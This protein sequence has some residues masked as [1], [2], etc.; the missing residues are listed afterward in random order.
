MKKL[1]TVLAS[2]LAIALSASA[3]S[4]LRGL[5]KVDHKLSTTP[6]ASFS[7][8]LKADDNKS[9]VRRAAAKAEDPSAAANLSINDLE[10]DYICSAYS[11]ASDENDK[12]YGWDVWGMTSIYQT[13][14]ASDT[15]L[16]IVGFMGT[17]DSQCNATFNPADGSMLIPGG[18]VLTVVAETGNTLPDGS[19]ETM[20]A[21]FKFYI[22]HLNIKGNTL[23]DQLPESN[24]PLIFTYDAAEH[25]YTWECEVNGE[26][27]S[28]LIVLERVNE[29]GSSIINPTTGSKAF[30]D[31]LAMVDLDA[32]NGI[33]QFEALDAEKSTK[34]QLAFAQQANYMYGEVTADNKLIVK[35]IYDYGFDIK[36]EFDINED[37]SISALDAHLA[38]IPLQ[39]SQ[40]S[41]YLTAINPETSELDEN[42][43]ITYQG[44]IQ[45]IPTEVG[46]VPVSVFT[47]DQML[48]DYDITNNYR[49]MWE[50]IKN[51][52][53]TFFF[54]AFG[55][56]GVEDVTVADNE[57]A[58]V[59]YFNLQGVRVA[60][61]GSGLY[62]VRQGAKTYKTF[63]K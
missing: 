43:P 38:D 56:A 23:N 48:V 11:Q 45:Q 44:E 41:F 46:N 21:Y 8:V 22:S 33:M 42:L 35:N 13:S 2:A 16:T 60:N 6:V 40:I 59:E 14:E 4:P 61:P 26:N 52:K 19:A 18:Q 51:S 15:D 36:L 32:I 31:M 29:D 62:I 37:K 7:T 3:A 49:F 54:N 39:G 34:D 55:A 17:G 9:L 50:I 10:V 24:D 30:I 1:Y 63:V 47:S 53:M 28:T 27:I 12:P 25:R 5:A 20:T 58:P 57:N